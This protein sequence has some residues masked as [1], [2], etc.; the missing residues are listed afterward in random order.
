MKEASIGRR[1]L[2]TDCLAAQE[3]QWRAALC[4]G[5][6]SLTPVIHHQDRPAHMWCSSL[7]AGT[8]WWQTTEP[9]VMLRPSLKT[10][11]IHL[12]PHKKKTL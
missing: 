10:R 11:E 6:V 7:T 9:K 2:R 12:K 5:A 8:K 3:P 1:S 4:Q